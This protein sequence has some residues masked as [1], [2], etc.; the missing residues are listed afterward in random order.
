MDRIEEIAA[1][2]YEELEKEYQEEEVT[3]TTEETTEEEA[4]EDV[5]EE[6][7][8]TTEEETTEEPQEEESEE[9]GSFAKLVHPDSFNEEERGLFDQLPNRQSKKLVRDFVDRLHYSQN[10]AINRKMHQLNTKYN[11]AMREV[12]SLD[13]LKETYNHRFNDGTTSTEA[14]EN[15]LEWDDYLE[16]NS[17]AAIA[18][19][20]QMYQVSPIDFI[21][22]PASRYFN[23]G[24][25][26]QTR[27]DDSALRKEIDSLK[28]TIAEDRKI[29][30]M[31]GIN[32]DI[33]TFANVKGNDGNLL[34][35]HFSN[36]EVAMYPIVQNLK[37][38]YP[39][40]TNLQLLHNAYNI[41]F[42]QA[43]DFIKNSVPMNRNKPAN[44]K[45][46]A[47]TP[48]SL[49]SKSSLKTNNKPI[50]NRT[51]HQHAEAAWNKLF[52]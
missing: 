44:Q 21:K 12:N 25:Q 43:P 33:N 17:H 41:A 28:A 47:K 2:A 10:Q 50:A 19:L 26:L 38:Q 35:P 6:G 29:Q 34:Y 32:R 16:N 5:P 30:K 3:E 45:K 51:P 52:G 15:S 36:L 27:P 20:M 39:Q 22:G 31:N 48:S 49:V 7:E 37:A 23:P 9:A 4:T 11:E 46:P 13:K 40:A 1:K 42:S 24:M 18:E 14:L 8:R